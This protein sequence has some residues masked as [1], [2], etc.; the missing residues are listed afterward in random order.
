[1][2][3]VGNDSDAYWAAVAVM[4]L[5]KCIASMPKGNISRENTIDTIGEH[6]LSI[7]PKLIPGHFT[8]A[9]KILAEGQ[10]A[11]GGAN[12]GKDLPTWLPTLKLAANTAI[13]TKPF[14]F[15][16]AFDAAM[17][18]NKRAIFDETILRSITEHAAK[19]QT[20]PVDVEKALSST[21]PHWL[22]NGLFKCGVPRVLRNDQSHR[23]KALLYGGYSDL[24]L[25]PSELVAHAFHFER[26]NILQLLKRV[27]EVGDKFSIFTLKAKAGTGRSIGLA[28]LVSHLNEIPRSTVYSCIGSVEITSDAL[29]VMTEAAA[30]ELIAWQNSSASGLDS[31]FL[32]LDDI[33]S[34]LPKQL[35]NL[36]R[37]FA[38]CHHASLRPEAARL[39]IILGSDTTLAL[40]STQKD[41]NFDLRLTEQDCASC[42]DVMAMQQPT[43]ICENPNGWKTIFTNHQPARTLRNAFGDDVQAFID[44]IL[45]HGQPLDDMRPFWLANIDKGFDRSAANPLRLVAVA[46][47]LG[48]AIPIR[49]AV[50]IFGLGM[51][52]S[53]MD[54]RDFI[55]ADHRLDIYEEDWF[56][57]GL[58]CPR[59]ARSMLG[60]IEWLL[61]VRIKTDFRYLINEA[62]DL[63]KS[64][65]RSEPDLL[66]FARH[67]LQRLGNTHDFPIWESDVH[68]DIS[69]KFNIG[70]SL[71]VESLIK[72]DDTIKCREQGFLFAKWAGTMSHF[73]RKDA[74]E[75]STY[76]PAVDEADISHIWSMSYFLSKKFL[77]A[78]SEGD[79]D[80]NSQTAVPMLKSINRILKFPSPAKDTSEYKAMCL[81]FFDIEK[82]VSLLS[83]ELKSESEVKTR[84]ANE[85]VHAYGKMLEVALVPL[86]RPKMQRK[87]SAIMRYL[88]CYMRKSN[89]EP[90]AGTW[91]M[92]AQMVPNNLPIESRMNT[93]KKYLDQAERRMSEDPISQATWQRPLKKAT[94]DLIIELKAPSNA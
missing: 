55:K 65:T 73:S 28:Q 40:F 35:E 93:R 61:P 51:N 6:F 81:D 30:A 82:M 44:F 94:K 16:P 74:M 39:I 78:A 85:L 59:R 75:S 26:E 34:V 92:R 54:L 12:F 86:A 19:K 70:Q 7:T 31:I 63:F 24:T 84:R 1:M 33:P 69:A 68:D 72:L 50:H 87:I 32:V 25:S 4:A 49:L 20:K 29:D 60:R 47:L 38:A 62:L 88:T 79:F 21:P 9:R 22:T 8:R 15:D 52:S 76:R 67:I 13:A 90:D 64:A 5:D 11:M 14:D 37:F 46:Q 3:S 43:I 48:L 10:D 36:Q 2:N 58:A 77:R 89:I 45:Q 66:E 18:Q 56:G 83:D 17:D 91:I 23:S 71:A 53:K 41:F 27:K 57:I 42:Y 80:N